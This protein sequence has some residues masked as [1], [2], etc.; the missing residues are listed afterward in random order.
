MFKLLLF[1]PRKI[2]PCRTVSPLD[3]LVCGSDYLAGVDCHSE[4]YAVR[5]AMT[6]HHNP[7]LL[8]IRPKKMP[9]KTK[10]F[11]INSKCHQ[12]NYRLILIS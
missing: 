2:R 11:M 10:T 7:W 5:K 3:P 6:L 12:F 1:F 8:L 9:L 4:V